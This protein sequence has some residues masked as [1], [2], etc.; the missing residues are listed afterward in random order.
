MTSYYLI[1]SDDVGRNGITKRDV[2]KYQVVSRGCVYVRK[3]E[4]EAK[5][6]TDYLNKG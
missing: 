2:G 4:H 3:C 5:Q 6:L 1:T